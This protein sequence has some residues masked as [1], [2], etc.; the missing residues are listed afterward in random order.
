[1]TSLISSHKDINVGLSPVC[2]P[3]KSYLKSRRK[4]F[5]EAQRGMILGM[6]D[7]TVENRNISQHSLTESESQSSI[8][9]YQ[10]PS[11]TS[12]VS[13]MTNSSLESLLSAPSSPE[14]ERSQ[15][16][17]TARRPEAAD[18]YRKE[19]NATTTRPPLLKQRDLKRGLSPKKAS[20]AARVPSKANSTT[21]VPTDLE[22]A[23]L[24][25]V[26][27][28]VM[29]CYPK[30]RCKTY[31]DHKECAMA[32][33]TEHSS[34]LCM[35]LSKVATL[36]ALLESR[37][38][39]ALRFGKGLKD[40]EHDDIDHSYRLQG[41]ARLERSMSM[42]RPTRKSSL[43]HGRPTEEKRRALTPSHI[44]VD[45][46]ATRRRRN[47]D[48]SISPR[49]THPTV[50]VQRPLSPIYSHLSSLKPTKVLSPRRMMSMSPSIPSQLCPPLTV[51]TSVRNFF[52]DVDA[53]TEKKVSS[54]K[55][56]DTSGH[57]GNFTGS[58]SIQTGKPHGRGRMV[59]TSPDKGNTVSYE[60]EW[61]QGQWHGKGKVI[62]KNGDT[63]T[64]SFSEDQIHGFGEYAHKGSKRIFQGRFVMGHRIEGK[65][66]YSDGSVYEGP[67]YDG[68]RQGIGTYHFSDGSLFKGEFAGDRMTGHGK[69]VWPDGSHYVGEFRK[70]RRHGNGTE[71]DKRGRTRY[72]GLWK[73]NLPVEEYWWRR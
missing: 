5:R 61:K 14:C 55:L 22:M 34:S 70:G 11:V 3:G 36:R 28:Q 19:L 51:A 24:K 33:L 17:L 7:R 37:L 47:T 16:S 46:E 38:E 12:T 69:L 68:K 62:K 10:Y 1:M 56:S 58:I 39:E 15:V 27:E 2:S 43:S 18:M 23:Q 71:Y 63:Y 65:M 60:G 64:G 72:E 8:S 54:A 20:R 42:P 13:T 44:L 31:T 52:K 73:D 9:K 6:L 41:R 50:L 48:R 40:E 53:P 35:T 32:E 30:G 67:W 45:D 59:Y 26:V 25:Y 66:K 21:T 29:K 49:L 57:L 4:Q